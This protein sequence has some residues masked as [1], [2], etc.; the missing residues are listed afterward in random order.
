LEKSN[1]NIEDFACLTAVP[2]QFIYVPALRSTCRQANRLR[3]V[4]LDQILWRK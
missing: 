2:F 4:S 3:H 1:D